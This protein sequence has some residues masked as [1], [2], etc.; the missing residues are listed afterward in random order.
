MSERQMYKDGYIRVGDPSDYMESLISIED[1]ENLRR[2]LVNET[3]YQRSTRIHAL[4]LHND[5]NQ[6]AVLSFSAFAGTK[7]RAAPSTDYINDTSIFLGAHYRQFPDDRWHLSITRNRMSR[8]DEGLS[9]ARIRTFLKIICW[10][11]QV[12][13]AKRTVK[14]I[15][16][17]PLIIALG[18]RMTEDSL[19][20]APYYK[21]VGSTTPLTP[22]HCEEIAQV[23][24][25]HSIRIQ[26]E[27]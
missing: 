2:T 5:D 23:I 14:F 26:H 13:E 24:T 3:F 12:M 16:A 25:R 9:E 19:A 6:D 8:V 4:E 10:G 21:R 22:E 1:A 18:A 7:T 27:R 20:A 11:D 15:K 17:T